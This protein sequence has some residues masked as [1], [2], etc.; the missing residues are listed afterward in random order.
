MTDLEMT[1]F[2][3]YVRYQEKTIN[4][5]IAGD[6]WQELVKTNEVDFTLTMPVIHLG[7]GCYLF[8][9]T[10]TY[11]GCLSWYECPGHFNPNLDWYQ[12]RFVRIT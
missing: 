12:Y 9:D 5:Y 6:L 2:E 7:L 11:P 3:M 10:E 8:Y 4:W 1:L